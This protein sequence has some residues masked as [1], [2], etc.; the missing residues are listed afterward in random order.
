MN[1]A[2][3]A[4]DLVSLLASPLASGVT[5]T[6]ASPPAAVLLLTAHCLLAWAPELALLK[7]AIDASPRL[8]QQSMQ[9]PPVG[10][11]VPPQPGAAATATTAATATP[12][13]SGVSAESAGPAAPSSRSGGKA[14]SGDGG[15]LLSWRLYFRQPVLL[16]NL[17]LAMLYMTVLSL[18][19]LMT[20]YLKWSGMVRRGRPQGG[21]WGEGGPG[22]RA[23]RLGLGEKSG[24]QQTR[25]G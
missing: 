11:A 19:F 15:C 21:G 22:R 20:S 7:W 8:R 12:G 17:S 13:G 24:G 5:M 9:A 14:S 3:R 10:D 2:F 4:I 18:G 16:A 6:Y 1:A 25:D 23:R